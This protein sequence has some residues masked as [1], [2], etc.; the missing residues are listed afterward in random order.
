MD[1]SKSEPQPYRL[2]TGGSVGPAIR[3]FRL[4]SGLTQVELADRVGIT[5]TYLSRLENGLET[6][7]L[8]RIVAVL[9]QLG[10][11]MTLQKEDW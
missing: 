8:R 10:V 5:P 7:Q 9:K 3:H 6:E 11:R 1:M 4:Q 2:Y